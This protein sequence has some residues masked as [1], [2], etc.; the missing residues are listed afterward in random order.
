M[1]VE[2]GGGMFRWARGYRY[3]MNECVGW[4]RR[5]SMTTA[6]CVLNALPSCRFGFY[7]G[8]R[9]QIQN[10]SFQTNSVFFIF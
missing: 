4:R 1:F 6:Y 3:A 2:G 10:V 9:F 5:S 7:M 8:V